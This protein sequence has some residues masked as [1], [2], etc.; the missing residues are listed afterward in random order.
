MVAI[1]SEADSSILF[2]RIP[3]PE[4]LSRAL[5]DIPGVVQHGLFLNMCRRAYVAGP[6]GVRVIDA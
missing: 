4:A 3:S 5:L 2:G 1:A 6:D